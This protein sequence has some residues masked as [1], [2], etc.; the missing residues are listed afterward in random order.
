MT[1]YFISTSN[2]SGGLRSPILRLQTE[3]DRARQEAT[4][5]VSADPGLALGAKSGRVVSARGETARL[6]ALVEANSVTT[7]RLQATQSALG[8]LGDV[9]KSFRDT[10]LG[11]AQGDPSARAALRQQA[12]SQL[13][14]AL[15][16]LNVKVGGR[17]LF[18][19]AESDVAPMRGAANGAQAMTNAFVATFGSTPDAPASATINGAAMRAFVQGAATNLFNDAN[20]A[21]DWSAVGDAPTR[22][23]ISPDEIIDSSVSANAPAIRKLT[24][25]LTMMSELGAQSL[26]TEAYQALAGEAAS[27][28]ADAMGG[29]T[30]LTAKA[31]ATSQR[32]SEASD[33]MS[34]KIAL[35][36][37]DM[38]RLE[39]VDAYEA[40]T[41]VT[42]LQTQLQAAFSMTS[43][44]RGLNLFDYLT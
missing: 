15:S 39:G 9:A 12:S 5:G 19:G 25:A 29:L 41:R 18:S 10:L 30:L 38:D 33:R 8:H 1:A 4:T 23:R 3:L 21:A 24:Q 44:L 6:T 36:S 35:L 40:A 14:Q 11:A 42:R 16:A 32:V 28:T 13:A 17:H 7:T 20:W 2:L 22:S 27:L 34:A 43:Q 37:G 26:N 31:G